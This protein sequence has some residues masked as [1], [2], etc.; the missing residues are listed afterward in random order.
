MYY[1]S[2]DELPVKTLFKIFETNDLL[3]LVK[4][5]SN[6]RLIPVKELQLAWDK[7]KDEYK[8]LDS[9]N[10]LE[11][12]IR[13]EQ[14]IDYLMA[15]HEMISLCVYVL[16]VRRDEKVEK[17]L[18]ENNYRVDPDNLEESL[19][20]IEAQAEALRTKIG[21]KQAELKRLTSDESIEKSDI[22]KMLASMSSSLQ[23]AF[24]FNEITVVEFFGFKDALEAKAKA[25]L[26][27]I[28]KGTSHGR[29]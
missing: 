26:K 1:R 9:S 2:V 8:E 16:R 12:V 7:I 3:L 18:K 6:Q 10:T 20:Q 17:L 19:N 22:N 28:N 27:P 15:K 25:Q 29:R 4:E 13:I 24:K 11:R 21:V 14:R 23:I 5:Y